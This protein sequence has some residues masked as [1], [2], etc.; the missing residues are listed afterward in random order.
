MGITTH[1][2]D[3]R[4]LLF[5]PYAK[6]ITSQ[7]EDALRLGAA[8]TVMW[9]TTDFQPGYVILWEEV[10]FTGAHSI[11]D[12][13]TGEYATDGLVYWFDTV[14]C[15]GSLYKADI[16]PLTADW[17]ALRFDAE[18]NGGILIDAEDGTVLA[19]FDGWDLPYGPMVTTAKQ[20]LDVGTRLDTFATYY[21]GADCQV[22]QI[23]ETG[24]GPL[25]DVDT[26]DVTGGDRPLE[27]NVAT[28]E[29]QTGVPGRDW[30]EFH[31]CE[32]IT[33][34]QAAENHVPGTWIR[35]VPVNYGSGS[36][37]DPGADYWEGWVLL[38]EEETRDA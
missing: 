24:A 4:R 30:E 3:G 14:N 33:A 11:V 5:G 28:G 23:S 22:Y 13:L 2:F 32:Y 10:A 7:V 9:C 12:T 19:R 37:D 18:M 21:V 6:H 31:D 36:S 25:A 17:S 35:R 16:Y 20:P 29:R 8:D 1:H 38:S 27:F 26:W 34:G 15:V